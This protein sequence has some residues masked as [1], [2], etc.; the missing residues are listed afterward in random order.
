VSAQ[1]RGG[2]EI[3]GRVAGADDSAATLEV[4]GGQRRLAYE[5]IAK[6]RVEV[7]FSRPGSNHD[8]ET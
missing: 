3:I 7:E 6:A 4:G 2:G 1:L 8:E 5:E